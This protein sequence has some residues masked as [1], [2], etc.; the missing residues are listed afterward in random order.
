VSVLVL[1]A[2]AVAAS[3]GFA[4]FQLVD[5]RFLGQISGEAV[6]AAGA[7]NQTLRQIFQVSAFGLSVAVQMMIALSVGR[8]SI[9]EAE[10]IAG[11]SF[12][13]TGLL[14]LIAICTVGLFPHYFVSLIVS[15]A[16]VPTA[17]TY[18][19][20]TFLFFA[21]NMFTQATNGILVG[22][23]DATTPMV[24]GFVQVPIAIFFEWVLAF[25]KLGFPALGVAGIAY[26]VAIGGACSFA[27][28][29][30]SLFSGRSRVHLRLRHLQP[31][32]RAIGRITQTAWQPAL[33]MVARSAMIM[34]FMVLAGR[35]GSHVQ[36]AYTIGL[37]IEMIAVM[38]AFPI[39]N[40]CA[41][42]VGQNLGARDPD[43]AWRAVWASAAIEV[44]ILWPGAVLLYFY[45]DAAVAIFTT[46]PLVAAEAAEYLR[47]VSFI[48][49]FWGLYFVAFRTLQAAGDMITPMAI[50]LV[51]AFGLG[52]PLAL[53]LSGRPE[54]G[55]SGMWIANAIYSVANTMLML[56]WLLTGRWTRPA[57]DARA[58]EGPIGQAGP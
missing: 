31:D 30:W 36:A 4:L 3:F 45:R 13:V 40:A 53:Y 58:A 46:D 48:L 21:F 5:L 38:I 35:I 43:R 10:H 42:L 1:A 32:W 51:L 7:T 15:D 14:A 27:L 2:P 54:F 11:Q 47:Y 16:A 33:Q 8:A 24:I 41:T 39:A 37:R 18:A 23:G 29:I 44:A 57:R 20:I 52:T 28:A 26:G 22:S 17:A 50:S 56:A 19:R 12:L 6:A 9:E 55:A 34:V 49:G 25:G